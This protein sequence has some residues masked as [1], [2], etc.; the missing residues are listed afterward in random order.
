MHRLSHKSICS[1]LRFLCVIQSPVL[2]EKLFTVQTS[3]DTAG[4][5]TWSMVSSS[6]SEPEGLIFALFPGFCGEKFRHRLEL[7]FSFKSMRTDIADVLYL[8]KLLIL[9]SQLLQI[10]RGAPVVI[11][12]PST[13]LICCGKPFR[14]PGTL[15]MFVNRSGWLVVS[16]KQQ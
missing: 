6:S 1:H 8:E 3:E 16:H 14:C 7:T 12:I 5:A 10:R 2:K 4:D 13:F 11:S 15:N 9:N